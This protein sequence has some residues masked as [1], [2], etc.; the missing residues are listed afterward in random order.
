M[1]CD[2]IPV[3]RDAVPAL[4]DAIAVLC[5]AIPALCDA[6]N[7]FEELPHANSTLRLYVCMHV[8]M[9]SYACIRVNLDTL[10]RVPVDSQ[11]QRR[12]NLIVKLHVKVSTAHSKGHHHI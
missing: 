6:D 3:L 1:L 10:Q 4:Y 2:A 5:D 12:R 7:T 11:V 9:R 8:R